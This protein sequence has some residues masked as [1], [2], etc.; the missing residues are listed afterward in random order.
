MIHMKST[1]LSIFIICL[2]SIP[3]TAEDQQVISGEAEVMDADVIRIGNQRVI[4]WGLDAPERN[5]SCY[6]N[7]ERWGCADAAKRVLELLAG[8]GEVTCYLTGEPDPFNR[9]YGVCES[10]G[11]QINDLMVRRGMAMAYTEQTDDFV[12]AQMEAI[13]EERGLWEVGVEFV[14]PWEFRLS[15]T[16]GGFR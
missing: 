16:P 5:Q 15:N 9:R 8:R 6:R 13:T 4:L 12:E 3:A 7:G 11:D 14:P 1:I 2:T 10:G